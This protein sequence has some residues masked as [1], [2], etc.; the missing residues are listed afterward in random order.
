MAAPPIT[1]ASSSCSFKKI[2]AKKL[3]NR[4]IKF[5]YIPALFA[6]NATT[7]VFQLKNATID[8]MTPTYKIAPIVV[9]LHTNDCDVVRSS[10]AVNGS[11]IN[12]PIAIVTKNVE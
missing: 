2:T 12:A 11:N 1:C 6:P 4:G 9:A 3:A 5:K 10:N 7:P 8:A